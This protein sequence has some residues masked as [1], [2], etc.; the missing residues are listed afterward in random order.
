[1]P[2]RG[3]RRRR[4]LPVVSS[5]RT[6]RPVVREGVGQRGCPA[7]V[8][9]DHGGCGGPLT[10]PQSEERLPTAPRGMRAG[11][12]CRR[13]W[14]AVPVLP[15]AHRRADPRPRAFAF[16]RSWMAAVA[17]LIRVTFPAASGGRG[18]AAPTYPSVA[19][20]DCSSF[21]P[22]RVVK[23]ALDRRRG[24]AESL[25]DLD[26]RQAFGFPVVPGEQYG[27]FALGHAVARCAFKG[28]HL[29]W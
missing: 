13:R 9:I 28:R 1:L 5:S 17:V 12:I 18:A 6:D 11:P 25:G 4:L 8:K 19:G 23:V 22:G 21:L 20:L 10:G 7:P 2:P 24:A 14:R 27:A 3:T 29:G 26:D 15:G 16:D